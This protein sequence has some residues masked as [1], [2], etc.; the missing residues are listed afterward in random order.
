[1]HNVGSF[2]DNRGFLVS[3][4]MKQAT[5]V[6]RF[7]TLDCKG[8]AGTT[9]RAALDF[10]SRG[11]IWRIPNCALRYILSYRLCMDYAPSFVFELPSRNTAS[12]LGMLV[13][14][15]VTC[16]VNYKKI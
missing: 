15:E 14:S 2:L 6:N 5:T 7:R 10:L 4:K 8:I 13:S 1:M 9:R 3:P 11:E 16:D 12:V